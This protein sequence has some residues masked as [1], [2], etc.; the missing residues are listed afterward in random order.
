VFRAVPV[1]LMALAGFADWATWAMLPQVTRANDYSPLA[2][3]LTTSPLLGLIPK[4]LPVVLLIVATSLTRG[5]RRAGLIFGF[6]A[7]LV[8]ACWFEGAWSN[9]VLF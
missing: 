1:G 7:L 9:V 5:D 4:A 2:R 6:V 8:A 3:L